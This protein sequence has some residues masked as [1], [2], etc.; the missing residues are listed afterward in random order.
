MADYPIPTKE[1]AA[2]M[3]AHTNLHVFGAVV[4]ILEGGTLSSYSGSAVRR[5]INICNKEQQRQLTLMDKAVA[6]LNMR[7]AQFEGGQGEAA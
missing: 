3:S 1:M 6:A 4:A 7:A 5:I 2:A